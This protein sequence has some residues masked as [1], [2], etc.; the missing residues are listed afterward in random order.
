MK[1]KYFLVFLTAMVLLA[2]A[3]FYAHPVF[4][5]NEYTITG[6]AYSTV[7]G[8]VDVPLTVSSPVDCSAS[9]LP[10]YTFVKREC[11]AMNDVKNINGQCYADTCLWKKTSNN[12]FEYTI[13]HAGSGGTAVDCSN[14]PAA[15]Y[16]L[17]KRVCVKTTNGNCIS[18]VC[19]WKKPSTA[20][21]DYSTSSSGVFNF[22]N[23]YGGKPVSVNCGN[24]VSGG[25]SLKQETCVLSATGCYSDICLL[26][27][28]GSNPTVTCNSNSD[29]GTNAFT[30]SPFCQQNNVY[31]NYVTYTCNNAGSANSFC[32]NSTSAQLKNNCSGNQACSNGSCGQNCS[33][34]SYQQCVGN[35]LYWFDS[36][37]VQQNLIQYC[38][39]GCYNNLCQNSNNNVSVQ[40]NPATNIYNNQVTLNGYLYSYNNNNNNNNNNYNNNYCSNYVWFQYGPSSSYGSETIHQSQNYT[41][42]FSQT[43][44]LYNNNYN[45]NSYNNYNNGSYHFRAAAQLCNGATVYGQDMVF[46]AGG[47]NGNSLTINKTVR[48]LT[49]GNSNWSSTAYASPSDTL[50]FMITL[51]ASGQDVQNVFV[52]DLLP[53]NLIYKNQLV[54]A[55]TNNNNY[56]YNN[57]N[58]YN[59]CSTGNYNNY[60]GDIM[61]GI[62]IGTIY[63][64]QTM[65]ITYQAQVAPIQNFAYGTSTLNNSVSVT[66]S[67]SGYNPT[68]NASIIVTR[69]AVY[70]A[71][72]VSTGLTNNFWVDSFFLPLLLTLIGIWIWRSGIF[73]GAEKWIDSKKKIRKGYKSEKELANRIA[74]IRKTEKA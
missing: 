7:D 6:N 29:C 3:V 64:G 71:S 19:L 28:A 33:S 15:G 18:D 39:N 25:Y 36:C 66:S 16:S 48:N 55:C 56:N 58:N 1:N 9:P 27:T 61:S 22:D 12:S 31:Q 11:L 57:Y 50:M 63:A 8:P 4:A 26:Q 60:S 54:V 14:T 52:R 72:T 41:G 2:G 32:S 73:F 44:N 37:G 34:N 24:N 35:N 10:G 62:N 43:V 13:T 51:Q 69:T 5:A 70:G 47:N 53:Q 67:N 42:S 17:E 46:T 65:T 23:I 21:F 49:S 38:P 40:T 20:L 68:S 74:M 59:N 45:Y 30:G